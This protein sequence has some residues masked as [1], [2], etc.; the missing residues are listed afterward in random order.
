MQYIQLMLTDSARGWLTSQPKDSFRTWEEFQDN[1]IKSFSGTFAR[2]TTYIELQACKQ[3]KD[4]SLRSYIQRWTLLR[5]TMEPVSEDRVMDAF[6][7]GVARRDLRE[8][9][10]R[11]QPKTT[12][13]LM[14]TAN[15]WAEG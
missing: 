13:E 10:G 12:I 7:H 2:P 3:G 14:K 4:E 11:L 1:F 8:E 9:F 5:N 15:Q 6:M